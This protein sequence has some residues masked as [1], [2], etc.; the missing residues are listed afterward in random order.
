MQLVCA[1]LCAALMRSTGW[2][3]G[4]IGAGLGSLVPGNERATVPGNLLRQERIAC[5]HSPRWGRRRCRHPIRDERSVR[6]GASGFGRATLTMHVGSRR[7]TSQRDKQGQRVEHRSLSGHGDVLL[8]AGRACAVGRVT[9]CW[10]VDGS[11]LRT[12]GRLAG[13]GCLGPVRH[14]PVL[15]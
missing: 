1:V 5:Q 15:R 6:G 3:W 11:L 7:F 8:L 12:R 14:L 4:P 10:Q 9:L 13:A 2:G